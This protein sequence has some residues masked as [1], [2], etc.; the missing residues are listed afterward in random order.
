[1]K[2]LRM[3]I[4][5][6]GGI[7]QAHLRALAKTDAIEMVAA[8]D[9]VEEKVERTAERWGI[10]HTFTDYHEL[11]EMDEIEAVTVSTWNMA[12]AQ[13]TIDALRSGRPV[14]CE[15]PMAA[16]LKDA[17]A[18]TAAAHET[19]QMLMIAVRPRYDRSRLAAKAIVDAGTIGDIYYAEAVACRRCG[20][21]RRESFL[22]KE[23]GGIGTIADIGVYALDAVLHLMGHPTPVSVS[24]VANNLLGTQCEP[25]MGCWEWD[26]QELEVEDFGVGVVRFENGA[27]LTFKTSW[28]M[29]MDN[30]GGNVLLGTKGGLRMNPLT[31]YRH[32]FGLLTDTT[33]QLPQDDQ[34]TFLDEYLGFAEAVREGL[35][36]PVPPEEMLITNVIIQGLVDSAEAGREVQVTV[37]EV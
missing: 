5:G 13:P 12:H 28:M 20:V 10:P 17:A 22:K 27:L 24:G 31:V 15:K 2:P 19:G 37:P 21:P 8:C 36:S 18:M 1:M 35:P 25:A 16:L 32:E 6:T 26:P 3:G 9:L 23:T 7:A 34:D 29:H 11:L 33:P 4:I 30:L 14:L